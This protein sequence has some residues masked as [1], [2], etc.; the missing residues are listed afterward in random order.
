M[1][2]EPLFSV[3]FSETRTDKFTSF[4]LG[5]LSLLVVTLQEPK[6]AWILVVFL[7][8]FSNRFQLVVHG[9]LSWL[10]VAFW[11]WPLNQA[12]L[13]FNWG[14]YYFRK[15][16]LRWPE[17]RNWGEH[18]HKRLLD[19][20]EERRAKNGIIAVFNQNFNKYSETFISGQN[21]ALDYSVRYYSGWPK[22]LH[23][24][25]DGNLVKSDALLTKVK[26]TIMNIFHEDVSNHEDHV[27]AESL[28][29]ENVSVIIAHF[30]PMGTALL[31]VASITGIPMIVMFHGYDAWNKKELAL[32][33]QQYNELFKAAAA[34]VGVSQDICNQL[35]S[36]GCP[37]EKI[38]YLPAFVNPSYFNTPY[39]VH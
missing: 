22:P 2:R 11:K 39:R 4:Q 26:Y 28:I 21:E 3:T 12:S 27:I 8:L 9:V 15:W 14:I 13:A 20:D 31:N 37:S 10:K 18:Y 29:E 1:G 19:L 16:V 38:E 35:K 24:A 30:G 25:G 23:L 6:F 7:L 33:E 17:E 34:V 32:Y 36:L 5:F